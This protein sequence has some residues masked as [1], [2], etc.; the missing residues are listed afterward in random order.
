[1]N[2]EFEEGDIVHFRKDKKLEPQN[3]DMELVKEFVRGVFHARLADGRILRVRSSD[4]LRVRRPSDAVKQKEVEQRKAERAVAKKV[5][6]DRVERNLEEFA[7]MEEYRVPLTA[8]GLPDKRYKP[9][10]NA[11]NSPFRIK[12]GPRGRI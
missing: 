10:Y 3:T 9:R 8:K 2:F 12:S 7:E 6:E 4:L 5:R 1:M 11:K